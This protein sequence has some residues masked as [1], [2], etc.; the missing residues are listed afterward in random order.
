MP[1]NQV[2]GYCCILDL[3]C[4]DGCMRCKPRFLCA[5]ASIAP[6]PG[7][8][9]ACCHVDSILVYTCHEQSNF[10]GWGGALFCPDNTYQ[11]GV[12]VYITRINGEC[13]TVV[14]QSYP[15]DPYP[16]NQEIF[17]GNL[18]D[19]MWL[20]VVDSA[21]NT[22]HVTVDAAPML[23]NPVAG[24]QCSVCICASCMP[25]YYSVH[26]DGPF[27]RFLVLDPNPLM[28]VGCPCSSTITLTYDCEHRRWTGPTA[29]CGDHRFDF[30]LELLPASSNLCGLRYSIFQDDYEIYSAFIPF[31]G[32]LNDRKFGGTK[33]VGDSSFTLGRPE[34]RKC[35]MIVEIPDPDDPDN[36]IPTVVPCPD[37][38]PQTFSTFLI[39]PMSDE[40]P[41][42]RN[43]IVL[44]GDYQFTLDQ[45]VCNDTTPGL[46]VSCCGTCTEVPGVLVL[47]THALCP[48]LDG[49]EVSLTLD[50]CSQAWHG[51]TLSVN[52]FDPT[53][54]K[55]VYWTL[56]CGGPE[57]RPLAWKIHQYYYDGSG[58]LIIT[59][60]DIYFSD[61]ESCDPFELHFSLS[62]TLGFFPLELCAVDGHL[63]G[64]IEFSV[65]AG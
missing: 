47:T 30:V 1:L 15:S 10:T 65:V 2:C 17:R 26:L 50:A 54:T 57:G 19:G 12:E 11:I 61:E 56:T 52:T 34:L 51:R 6:G 41:N 29:M 16:Y 40:D 64:N 33:C 38:P 14:Q 24:D 27:T 35:E 58:T 4:E 31:E 32:K 5:H 8:T 48:N 7:I 9:D 23:P 20:D 21:G 28:W 44:F 42:P 53:D 18:P 49:I 22:W 43:P 55:Y 37:P 13:C 60:G 63:E 59:D 25:K 45:R 62:S 39:G 46:T 36:T 3:S